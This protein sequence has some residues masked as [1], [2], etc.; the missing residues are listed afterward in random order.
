LQ[1][2]A[3]HRL[4]G[5]PR[6]TFQRSA[7]L[8]QPIKREPSLSASLDIYSDFALT[9]LTSQ[10][11]KKRMTVELSR[12]APDL[13]VIADPLLSPLEGFFSQLGY[14]CRVASSGSAAWHLSVAERL[15]YSNAGVWHRTLGEYIK[16]YSPL[17]AE[18]ARDSFLQFEFDEIYF[19][20]S[21]S[22]VVPATG[23]RWLDSLIIQA[24]R[25]ATETLAARHSSLPDICLVGFAQELKQEAPWALHYPDWQH[26]P[27][28]VGAARAL[29]A[30]WLSPALTGLAKA[31]L[32][33]GTV[34]ITTKEDAILAGLAGRD[35]V[36]IQ[37]GDQAARAMLLALDT[38]IL[39]AAAHRRISELSS[40]GKALPRRYM[41]PGRRV[42]PLCS[43][44]VVQYNTLSKMVLV[45][46]NLKR[47]SRI[48]EV[49]L[50]SQD[51]RELNRLMPNEVQKLD[52][53]FVLE[54]AAI[55]DLEEIGQA[56]ILEMHDALGLVESKSIPV[57]TFERL[58]AE[59]A[60]VEQ[61]GST[62]RGA[63]WVVADRPAAAWGVGPEGETYRVRAGGAVPMPE[64]GGLAITFEVPAE[65]SGGKPI[66]IS[67]RGSN[68]GAIFEH[69]VQRP[70]LSGKNEITG[71]VPYSP[72]AEKLKGIHTGERAWI[73]GNGPSVRPEDLSRIP[74][75]DVIFAFNRFY[76]SYENHS[77]R[78]DYVVSAD[79]LMIDDF[80]QEMID[81]ASGL[82]LFV[83]LPAATQH[84]QSRYENLPPSDNRLPVFSS[85][86]ARSISI[87]GS[88]VYVALQI[89]HYMGIREVMLYGIDYSF[90]MR[91]RRDPRYPFPVSFDD[92]NHFIQSYR[93]AK[94]W[95]PPT[96]RDISAG[97]LNARVIYETTGGRVVNVTRG[98]RLETFTRRNFDEIIV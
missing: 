28:L 79:M 3:D 88:S 81:V 38:E 85:N 11:R 26:L 65:L 78:E 69:V 74:K 56:L 35:G 93:G 97:F 77:L 33:L 92:S 2:T 30:P 96:W 86:I 20:K 34:V 22:I 8:S 63:F 57:E 43:P 1:M 75:S 40:F 67:S 15:S 71:A 72:S 94:P 66:L 51:G 24:V 62:I 58:D 68:A 31:A 91:L 45:R 4:I 76:L 84:L 59:I 27:E 55:A 12:L 36:L 37:S 39:D 61:H 83:R 17:A 89:A 14:N 73:I 48:E 10:R 32:S 18:F 90:N 21:G 44:V 80:G 95:C 53:I 70:F 13:I 82:P 7:F 41:R 49:R 47:N 9:T 29:Y 5:L 16:R 64:V 25:P 23:F 42:S 60:S 50:K 52:P 87:G 46:L 54:G 19:Q 98:G 6:G